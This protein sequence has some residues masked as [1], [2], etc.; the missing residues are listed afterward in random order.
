MR[1]MPQVHTDP[2]ERPPPTTAMLRSLSLAS[3][4]GLG[5]A[6]TRR[7]IADA[8]QTRS[9]GDV[10]A[11]EPAALPPPSPAQAAPDA[12]PGREPAR[13]PLLDSQPSP[14]IQRE[15]RLA[16][17]PL[18]RRR[19]AR[20]MVAR[21]GATFV[22]WAAWATVLVTLILQADV[23]EDNVLLAVVSVS[24]A[25]A[26]G[27]LFIWIG[28]MRRAGMRRREYR[29]LHRDEERQGTPSAQ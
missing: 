5:R 15:I 26:I 7:N 22:V 20:G 28:D 14:E 1:A 21:F 18:E 27:S 8:T 13:L 29:Q 17:G 3:S 9:P 16:R 6:A 10:P 23:A 25:A 12:A 4:R 24:V 2:D 11:Q 19:D